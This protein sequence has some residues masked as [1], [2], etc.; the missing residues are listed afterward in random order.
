VHRSAIALVAAFAVATPACKLAPPRAAQRPGQPAERVLPEPAIPFAPR[1][2]V[3]YRTVRP[4]KVDGLLDEAG[5]RAAAW[6]EDFADIEGPAKPAPR[7]RTR[8]KMLWDSANLYIGAE[9]TEPDVWATITE[10]DA[11]IFRDN[12]FEVFI[13]P[14]G[15]THRY[16]E[17]EVNALGTAWDLFLEK[18][19]RDDGH[20]LTGWDIHGLQVGAHVSGTLNRPTD[21]DRGWT[22]ELALPWASLGEAAGTPVPPHPGDQWRIDFSRVEWR[23]RVEG[24]RTVKVTDPATGRPLPEDNWVWSPQGVVNMHYPEMWG[25]VQFS[26]QVAGQGADVFAPRETDA[27]KWMLRVLY[28]REQAF[29]ARHGVFTDDLAKLG[30]SAAPRPGGAWASLIG[31]PWPPAIDVTPNGYEASLPLPESADTAS[32]RGNA[33]G[34]PAATAPRRLVLTADG[35]VR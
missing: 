6:T 24:G 15:D 3:A 7:Y 31:R 5:W 29:H 19:Y 11:V 21:V 33:A 13:D 23:T 30:L 22:V 18:P 10:R 27:L 17:L 14:D 12:D 20:A 2:Y 32:G 9:L 25:F 26:S 28:Y 34:R 8:A 4:L 16:Y 35:A 1:S